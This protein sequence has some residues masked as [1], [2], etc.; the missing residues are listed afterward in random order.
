VERFQGRREHL[1]LGE[2]FTPH[3]D[4]APVE[5]LRT[6]WVSLKLRIF[7]TKICNI[8]GELHPAR[9]LIPFVAQDAGSFSF[10]V[11]ST[12]CW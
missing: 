10:S 9:Y 4:W 1:E 7:E 11:Q 2:L 8:H 12:L 5:G 3:P 6:S